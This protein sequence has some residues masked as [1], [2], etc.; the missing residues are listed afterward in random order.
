MVTVP[1]NPDSEGKIQEM[2]KLLPILVADFC[3]ENESK[4]KIKM[5]VEACSFSDVD[6]NISEP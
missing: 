5:D 2:Q 3:F 6:L 1:T 4:L